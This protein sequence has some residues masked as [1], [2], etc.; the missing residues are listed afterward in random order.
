MIHIVCALKCEALPLLDCF[1]LDHCSKAALFN[2]YYN[3]VSQLSLTISGVGKVAAAAATLHTMTL[4]DAKKQDVWLN[5]GVAGHGILP[6]GQAVLANRVEDAGSGAVWYPQIV[7]ATELSSGGLRTLD[8]PVTD[9]NTVMVD[10]EGA[11]FYASA[12]RLATAELCH[13]LKIISDNRESPADRLQ[14]SFVRG[15]I[16]E[17]TLTIEKLIRQLRSLSAELD[18]TLTTPRDY[19][20]CVRRWRFTRY[21]KGILEQLLR[22]WQVLRPGNPALQGRLIQS[23]SAEEVLARLQQTL[24]ENPIIFK[25]A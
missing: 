13:C 22:R 16:A 6:V 1:K 2:T 24:D 3:E 7:F 9:Y 19:E 23:K 10:M 17:H 14:E 21:Q 15:L 18:T 20:G 12:C 8:Q 5:I 25:Q 4:F 11:G